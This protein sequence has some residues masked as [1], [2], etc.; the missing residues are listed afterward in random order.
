MQLSFSRAWAGER[1]VP[2]DVQGAPVVCE[3]GGLY[4]AA[5]PEELLRAAAQQL[6][7]ALGSRL[8]VDKPSAAIDYIARFLAGVARSAHDRPLEVAATA[9]ARDHAQGAPLA[10]DLARISGMVQDRLAMVQR[11]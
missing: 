1:Q 3:A 6:E 7:G 8:P 10:T 4:R 2:Q 5:T 11:L 9:L